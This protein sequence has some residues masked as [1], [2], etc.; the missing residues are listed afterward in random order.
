MREPSNPLD[1]IPNNEYHSLRLSLSSQHPLTN[2]FPREIEGEE[3]RYSSGN[4]AQSNN[5]LSDIELEVQRIREET[6]KR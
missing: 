5:N 3:R 2:D 6:L 4:G 1:H